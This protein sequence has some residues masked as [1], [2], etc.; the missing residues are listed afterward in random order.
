MN[1]PTSTPQDTPTTIADDVREFITRYVAL[2][3]DHYADILALYAVHTHAFETART[4]PYI[5]LTSEGPGSG[6]TRVMEVMSEICRQ[7]MMVAGLTGATFFRLIEARRPTFFMDEVDTIYSGAKNEELRGVLNS[8]YKHNGSIARVDTSSEDGF[9]D[10]S[11]FCPKVLAGI[12]NGQVPDTVLD[13]SIKI[14]LRKAPA[15]TVQPFYSEDIED[16]CADLAQ[17][18]GAW[19]KIHADALRDRRNRP[20]ALPE[21]SDRQNDI[22]RPLIIIADRLSPEWGARARAAFVKA[23]GP[24]D[25]PLSPQQAALKA[26][27]DWMTENGKDRIPSAVLADLVG[28]NAHRLGHLLRPMEVAPSTVRVDG[29]PTKCYTMEAM[30]SAWARF[31]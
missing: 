14:L 10:F 4:T 30:E 19:V 8:G 27:Q 3:G 5:Y 17:A 29:K 11:T 20:E 31:I 9:R 28:V 25:T 26:A 23:L 2:P 18:M 7:S 16:E 1:N 12:D 22:A 24:Q 6:K 21:L 13:R 15:G